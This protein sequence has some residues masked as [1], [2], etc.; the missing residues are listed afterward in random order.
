MNKESVFFAIL[1]QLEESQRVLQHRLDEVSSFKMAARAKNLV[2]LMENERRDQN[3]IIS[4]MR[5][6]LEK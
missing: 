4:W 2:W 6:E 1:L 5:E 3:A